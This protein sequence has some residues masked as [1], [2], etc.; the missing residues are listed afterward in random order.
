VNRRLFITLLGSAATWPL[1]AHAQRT[2]AVR[3][4]GVLMPLP[5]DD[6]VGRARVAAFREA[7]QQR[8]WTEGRNIRVHY[9]WAVDEATQ[10]DGEASELVALAPE[11]IMV[12]GSAP[13]AALQRTTHLLPIVFVQVADPVGA[14]FVQ[15]LARPGGNVTGFTPLEYGMSAKWLELLKQIA[16]SI[17]RVAVL[18]EA[19]N[20]GGLGQTAAIQ[21]A[22]P[23]LGV[24]V[25]A[26]DSRDSTEIALN[27]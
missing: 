4:I 1:A 27:S 2:E 22:A 14:G 13:T 18:R 15:S 3:R 12:T 9:R 25:S 19:T 10:F 11:V 5:A 6:P 16:P 24:E 20:P 8:G 26:F 17:R 7:L 21:S 23:S